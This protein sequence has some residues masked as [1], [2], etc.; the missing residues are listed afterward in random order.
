MR[1][2][3]ATPLM[4]VSPGATSPPITGAAPPRMS[5]APAPRASTPAAPARPSGPGGG[6]RPPAARPPSPSSGERGAWASGARSATAAFRRRFP[7]SKCR[8]RARS[9]PL[10][11][12]YLLFI[13]IE[14]GLTDRHAA[15]EIG[16][17]LA[18]LG[19]LQHPK[20]DPC[21]PIEPRRQ[22]SR[23]AL[24]SVDP[25]S[26]EA[27]QVCTQQAPTVRPS[28]T[29][30]SRHR[31]WPARRQQ[32]V[33]ADPPPRKLSTHEAPRAA[34]PPRRDRIRPPCR[35]AR[36]CARRRLPASGAS[37]H[38]PDAAARTRGCGDS[39]PAPRRVPFSGLTSPAGRTRRP[40]CARRRQKVEQP[41]HHRNTG[42]RR[43]VD[44]QITRLGAAV[45]D[46]GRR[47]LDGGTVGP[48][49]ERCAPGRHGQCQERR[50]PAERRRVGQR[51]IRAKPRRQPAG[52]ERWARRHRRR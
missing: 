36:R 42:D 9:W 15:A 33:H 34:S 10:G 35:L 3:C 44:E 20:E 43:G 21:W 16:D 4:T 7:A 5:S 47:D 22:R 32:L 31:V 39:P 23:M 1:S 30:A 12:S 8:S 28:P 14:G 27:D 24:T 2:M 25:V 46:S 11:P 19:G 26:G 48:R 52:V 45:G 49:Q 6:S 17:V 29:C 50:Q 41:D 51:P 18:A 13:T 40:V 37:D 38:N